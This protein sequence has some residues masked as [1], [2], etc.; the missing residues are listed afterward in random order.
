[1]VEG[2]KPPKDKGK[3]S[4]SREN[5]IDQYDPLFLH[6]NDTNGVPII[7]FKHEGTENY[8]VW[9]AAIPIAIHTKNKLGFING[10]IPR[11]IEEGFM[12]E[13]WDRCNSVVLNWIL[14]YVSQDVFMGQVFSKNA[15][16]VWDE[17]EETYS[18]QDAFVIFNMHYKI[19]SL[20]QSGSAL[21][22]YYHKFNALWRSIILTI[23]P[24]PDVRG[25]F[26]TLSKDESHK[27]SQNSSLPKT[28][29]SAFVAR[30]NNRNNNW[31]NN[32][33][34][35]ARKLN[36]PNLVCT[37]YNMNG[38]TADRC[39]ELV[40]YPPNFKKSSFN[41]NSGSSNVVSRNKDKSTSNSFTDD[42]FKKLMALISDKSG[43]SSMPANIAGAS[44]H[45]TY[46]ILNMFNVVEVSKLNMIVGHPNGTKAIV[47]HVGSL[48]LT[49]QI[50]IHD[51]L[52]VPGYEDSVQRTQVG[53]GNKSNGLYFL[54][55]GKKFVNNNIEICCLSK[56][57]WHNILGHPSD[58][59]LNVLKHK[60]D[61][62]KDKTDV[63]G[64]YK[65]Q[66]REGYEYFF[67]TIVDDF[68]SVKIFRSDNGTEFINQS[69]DKFCK[70]KGI[71]YQTSCPYTPQQNGVAERKHRHLLN[72]ARA[73]MF[74][75]GIPL[76]M[77]SECVL[78]AVYLINRLPSSVLS[79]KLPYELVFC[80]EPN[81]SHLKTFGCLCF[82]TVLNDFDSL[83]S[84][85]VFYSRDV[86]FYETVFPFKN[87]T[88]CKEYEMVFQNKNSLNFFNNDEDESKSED[89]YDDRRDKEPKIS[90]GI[91]H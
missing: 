6:C 46:T 31:N 28:G 45:M 35:Q 87:S 78:T 47:T 72:V 81:L 10:K 9:K 73:L 50:V 62:E 7:G 89:P 16:T 67:F 90:E 13:Q 86:K 85:K 75:G 30:P 54:N 52:V 42:Q 23:D 11:P 57:I 56:C 55:T 91:D 29:N 27:G 88:E 49:D 58:Q 51:V 80:Y 70:E 37:H 66:S 34:N 44:Q 1:M 77:W 36:R 21:S 4:G 60:L 14:G 65:V 15:K 18:K 8:K 24:I 17:L 41:K 63:W 5:N 53:T 61:F 25:A 38:H 22:K 40:G 19:H 76:N 82:S 59:V 79:G 43:S 26:A 69:M 12:Q 39:F 74:Q 20:S 64:P 33:N 2:D 32:N 83:E 3:G 71:L 68:S 84:K 48:R